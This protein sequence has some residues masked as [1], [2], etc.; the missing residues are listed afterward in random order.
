MLALEDKKKR[1]TDLKDGD[2]FNYR[3]VDYFYN[4]VIRCFMV[5]YTLFNTAKEARDYIDE[6]IENNF[7]AF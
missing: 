4:G 6:L 1:T 2:E 3:G 7:A 5:G